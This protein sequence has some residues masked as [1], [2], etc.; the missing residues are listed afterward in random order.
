MQILF[1]YRHPDVGFSIEKVFNTLENEI[2]K[3]CVVESVSVASKNSMP[4]DI[5]VNNLFS[6]KK[7][8]KKGV[9]HITG[10]IHDVILGLIGC[11]SIV[12]FHDL[13]F[14]D[15]VRNPVKKIYK[16]L[17]WV[18]IPVKFADS[19]T[20]ISEHTKRSLLRHVKTDK[21][22][23][24]HNPIDPL[25]EFKAKQ[26]NSEK[27]VI[28]HIGTGWNKNLVNTIRALQGIS[29]HLRIIGKLKEAHLAALNEHG[30]EFSNEFG[31]TDD[32]IRMEYQKCDIVNFPSVYEGFGMPII[33]GQ[34][35]GRVV[36][37]SY[38]EPL[39][40]VGQES[41]HFVD[42]EDIASI[43]AGYKK[44]IADESYREQ[45]ISRGYANVER[46]KVSNIAAQYIELY[47]KILEN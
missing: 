4:W 37:T 7:R 32:Q 17:F 29:C 5:I 45:L 18:Y 16:W 40:E 10:H 24:I 9:N 6:F 13:V 42:P 46:F 47:Q 21:I 3:K 35:T 31:L 26:F 44:I 34:A 43:N 20:C 1:F 14:L 22:T 41:V 15:N 39:I 2:Q 12:T 38:L 28:L 36:I 30:V 8:N 19:I 25:F 33:E 27:P 23:V 11:K